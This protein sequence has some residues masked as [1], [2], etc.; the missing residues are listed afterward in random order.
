MLQ[1]AFLWHQ[2]FTSFTSLQ[3]KNSFKR[4]CW[5]QF[6]NEFL[7]LPATEKAASKLSQRYKATDE[8]QLLKNL[9]KLL[10][11]GE[12]ER[13]SERKRAGKKPCKVLTNF[14]YSLTSPS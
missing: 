12:R 3:V 1:S 5:E 9:L 8:K 11:D 7:V 4:D 14:Y 6:R 10:G 13:E 2:Q